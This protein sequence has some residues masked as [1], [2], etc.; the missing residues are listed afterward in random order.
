MAK[1]S[2]LCARPTIFAAWIYYAM[3]VVELCADLISLLWSVNTTSS[4]LHVVFAQP[5]SGR[6]TRTTSMMEKFTAITIIR[7]SL[8]QGAMGAKPP[9]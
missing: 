8:P 2:T 7:L 1:G 3:S 9:Y 5:F 4:I 6:R